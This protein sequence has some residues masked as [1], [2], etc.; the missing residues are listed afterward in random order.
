MNI[1]PIVEGYGEVAAVPV[2]LRRLRDEF[3][4]WG[5]DVNRP[6]R[7]RRSELV[8]ET[9]LRRTI[10]LAQLQPNCDAILILFD[11]DRDCPR[12]LAPRLRSWAKSEAGQV[13]CDVV[14]AHKEYEAWFLATIE[15]LRGKRGI[16]M[17]A[18]SH[19]D[20]EMPR[21]AKRH[22]EKRMRPEVSYMERAD[23]PALSALFDLKT[24]YRKCR[25]FRKLAKAFRELLEE[26][27][28]NLS[29]QLPVAWDEET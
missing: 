23:Q 29:T 6:I 19:P 18:T 27:G 8:Q 26:M 21:G 28:P 20:P 2:L 12:K 11:S 10:R 14:M 24:A 9:E 3:H 13:P 17:D 15:S 1:Q 7:R 16:R 5:V 4:A 25:S 22:L